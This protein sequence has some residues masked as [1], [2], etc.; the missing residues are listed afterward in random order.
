[1]KAGTLLLAALGVGAVGAGAYFIFRRK[2][3][4]AFASSGLTAAQYVE[5][6]VS[7]G[8]DPYAAIIADKELARAAAEAGSNIKS[9]LPPP[10]GSELT[11]PTHMT[12]DYLWNLGKQQEAQRNG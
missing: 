1:M 12:F 5:K 6:I 9:V 8:K 4:S 10:P 11:L 3:T 7:E 2:A